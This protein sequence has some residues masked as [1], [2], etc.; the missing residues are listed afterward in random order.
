[1]KHATAGDNH[2]IW[3]GPNDRRGL[4]GVALAIPLHLKKSL[5]NWK[6][7]ID[8]LL[9]ARLQHQH[10][11]MPIIVPYSP[12]DVAPDR[13]KDAFYELQDGIQAAPPHD[14]AIVL[15]DANATVSAD[16][17]DPA[18]QA[19]TGPVSVSDTTNDNGSRLIHLCRATS[20]CIADTWFP[21]KRIHHWTWHSPDGRTKKAIDHIILSIC[22]RSSFT[23]F[24][25]FRGAQLGNTDHRMLIADMRLKLKAKPSATGLSRL[26]S[27]RIQ[28]P[29]N[30]ELYNCAISNHFTALT[31]D[32]LIDW[33]HFK[34]K[35]F[36]ATK[37]IPR[38]P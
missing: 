30:K 10:G 25:V 3:R 38:D 29:A 35:V 16:S 14:S 4:Y 27:S 1:M 22:W 11:K 12:M 19:V 13:E 32:T 21:R 31:D 33:Q 9:S 34:T 26:D 8:W 36:K 20:L 24:R 7:I 28:D 18:L 5:I 6:P 15:T 17:H 37:D 23:N 2:F